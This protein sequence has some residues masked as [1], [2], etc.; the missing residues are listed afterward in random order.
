VLRGGAIRRCPSWL[1]SAESC[2]GFGLL[3]EAIPV[4]SRVFN[5]R[6][7]RRPIPPFTSQPNR[8]D[9]FPDYVPRN[10]RAIR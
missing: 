4:T 6:R 2:A 8:S 10:R 7:N 3:S 5:C 9:P 1:R